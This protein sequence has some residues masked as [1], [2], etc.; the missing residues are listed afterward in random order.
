M[1]VIESVTKSSD[2]IMP[3][4]QFPPLEF[5]KNAEPNSQLF[6]CWLSA[7]GR[8]TGGVTVAPVSSPRYV[9]SAWHF[10]IDG[11]SACPGGLSGSP[12][13]NTLAKKS[14]CP[15]IW[16]FF[17]AQNPSF[18]FLLALFSFSQ[19]PT[20]NVGIKIRSKKWARCCSGGGSEVL[21][22]FFLVS[23]IGRAVLL[24]HVN[25]PSSLAVEL[26]P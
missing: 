25:K 18:L 2:S 22:K 8:Q 26:R 3:R 5:C 21:W 19:V 17:H 1:G 13:P 23:L 9:S 6:V 16:T 10:M 4:A 15:R 12:A 7:V 24:F 14:R 20:L 11:Q